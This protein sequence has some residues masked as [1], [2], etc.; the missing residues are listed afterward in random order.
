M[1]PLLVLSSFHREILKKSKGKR[2]TGSQLVTDKRKR[3]KETGIG[4]RRSEGAQETGEKEHED[5]KR[6]HSVAGTSRG[7]Q[8]KGRMRNDRGNGGGIHELGREYT[9]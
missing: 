4:D 6:G 8:R 3:K 9:E 2:A 5:R 1:E 7:G